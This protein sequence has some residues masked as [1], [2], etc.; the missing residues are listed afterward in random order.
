MSI[1]NLRQALIDR[2]E[3]PIQQ[4]EI[5]AGSVKTSYL[6]AGNG[7]LVILL[8]GAGAGAVPWYRW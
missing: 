8:H 4:G 7:Q 5:V 2:I 1:V 6:S 3:T